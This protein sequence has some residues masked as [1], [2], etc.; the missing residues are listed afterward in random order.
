MEQE[1]RIDPV[2]VLREVE[3]LD[4]KVLALAVANVRN[5]QQEQVI[6][7]LRKELEGG[8]KDEPEAG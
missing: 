7:E 5:A 3:R 4:S 1:L 2:D 6:A 8:K